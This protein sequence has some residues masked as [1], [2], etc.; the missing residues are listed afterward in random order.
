[1][2]D[3]PVM[4]KYESNVANEMIKQSLASDSEHFEAEKN[5][6]K[7]IVQNQTDFLRQGDGLRANPFM[8]QVSQISGIMTSR[9]SQRSVS[10]GILTS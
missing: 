10:R 3:T 7:E 4:Q 6:I 8:S 5:R 1:M 9:H 2:K